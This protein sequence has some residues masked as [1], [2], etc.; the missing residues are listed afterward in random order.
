VQQQEK[1]HAHEKEMQRQKLHQEKK[2]GQD[3]NVVH[4]QEKLREEEQREKREQDVNV[5]HLQEK[6]LEEKQQEKLL[7]EEEQR[8]DDA[9]LFLFF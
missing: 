7:L 5:V 4:L 2:Q 9:D 1:Q 3:V 6:L 8:K